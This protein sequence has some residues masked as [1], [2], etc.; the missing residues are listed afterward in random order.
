MADNAS[1]D[2][3]VLFLKTNFPQVGIISNQVNVGFAG[4]YNQAFKQIKADF[5]VLLNQDVEVESGWIEPI[6]TLM[7]KQP[8]IAVCQP[9]IKAFYRR[10]CFEYAGAAGGYMDKYGY[11]FCRGRIFDTIEE[12]RGQ[13]DQVNEI[14][15][16]SGA[17]MFVR[18]SVYHSLGGMDDNFFAHMEEIDLCWRIHLAGYRICYC[19]ESVVYHI[20]GGSLSRSDPRKTFLNYRNNLIMLTKNLP[21]KGKSSVLFFRKYLDRMAAVKSLMQGNYSTFRAIIM[22][23]REYRKWL[24]KFNAKSSGHSIQAKR[25][26]TELPGIYPNSIIWKYYVMQKKR[27]SDLGFF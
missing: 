14:F 11:P 25:S 5:Y 2:D 19:P 8:D 21:L 26:L 22:A 18:S 7:F 1:T 4:G 9:K 17:A 12:D 23:H 24:R 13:Y 20:G 27:F 6:V 3:T 15:W 16:A 10:S